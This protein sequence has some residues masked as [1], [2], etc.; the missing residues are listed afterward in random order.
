MSF[1][2]IFAQ[3]QKRN[4]HLSSLQL[5]HHLQ[6]E[7]YF[8][9]PRARFYSAEIACALGYLHSM[10]IIYRDLKPEN[11]L[12]DSEVLFSYFFK[13]ISV[14]YLVLK[15]CSNLFL[16]LAGSHPLDRFRV[17]QGRC[18]H[19]ARWNYHNVLWYSRY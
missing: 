15:F 19:L 6:R 7:R 16:I 4:G 8:S 10:G 11:L 5:F 9:E 17:V 12:L 2:G 13:L 18:Q 14:I 3:S 1:L